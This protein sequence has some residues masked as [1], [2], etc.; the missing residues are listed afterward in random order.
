MAATT[1]VI[2]ALKYRYAQ[3][4]DIPKWLFNKE[5]VTY[6]I[7]K[8][9][10]QRVDGRGQWILPIQKKLPTGFTGVA[11][12]GSR[13]SARQPS[14]TEAT[15]SLQEYVGVYDV[16]WKLLQDAA[17]SEASF[18]DAVKFLD[19]GLKTHFI[20]MLNADLMGDG[21]GR[22]YS[23]PAADDAATHTAAE[24]PLIDI[25]MVVDVMDETDHNTKLGDSLT[26]N[27][28]T[29][30]SK[31]VTLSGAPSGTAAGDYATIQDTVAT[32]YSRHSNGLLSVVS[33][34]NPASP[35]GNYG[36]INRSTA[37]NEFWEAGV[38]SN[39]GTNRPLTE[40]L[41]IE[42]LDT[43]RLNGGGMVDAVISNLAILRRYHELF[44]STVDR[45]RNT[46]TLSGGIGRKDGGKE[47]KDDGRSVY[48]FS[49]V[50]WHVEPYFRANRMVFLDTS[51][52]F[53][54]TGENEA[55]M[56]IS[57]IFPEAPFFYQ[58]SNTTFEVN[59]YM[60]MELLSDAPNCHVLVSDISES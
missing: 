50:P 34:A 56:P 54:G 58:T 9:K 46:G 5:S 15:F 10:K 44:G 37:G 12:G 21:L 36:G 8:K 27:A 3:A 31:S 33:N 2:N 40:D 42:A 16:T 43:A 30:P 28:F 7:L 6:N 60:Q 20:R 24:V 39:S 35:V 11:E 14:T 57:E 32:A 47:A 59:W 49:G 1:D 48:D 41:G 45:F 55:P 22:L 4:P 17:R 18:V 52:L 19:N 26:V 29:L 23:F 13:P 51:R 53:I 25:G 38:L